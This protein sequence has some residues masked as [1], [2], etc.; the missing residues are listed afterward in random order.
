M[1]SYDAASDVWQALARGVALMDGGSQA[2]R[3]SPIL[4][5]RE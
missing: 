1:A 2:W 5:V 4:A 3:P